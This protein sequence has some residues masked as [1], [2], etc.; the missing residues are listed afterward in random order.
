[1]LDFLL[2]GFASFVLPFP[3]R[4]HLNPLLVNL[5]EL[6]DPDKLRQNKIHARR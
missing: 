1:M 5:R 6:K 3:V 2:A 4:F